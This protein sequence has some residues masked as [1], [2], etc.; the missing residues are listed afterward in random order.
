MPCLN[1]MFSDQ[2]FAESFLVSGWLPAHGEDFAAWANLLFG[3]TVTLQTPAHLHGLRLN[4]HIHLINPPMTG[5]AAHTLFDMNGMV[6]I[7]IVGQVMHT[8]PF[9]R[10]VVL[11]AVTYQLQRR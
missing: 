4:H 10:L 11:Q 8:S 3:C 2:L 7:D 5:F 1:A 6:K 9:Q